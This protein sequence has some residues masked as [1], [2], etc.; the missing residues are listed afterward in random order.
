[1][2]LSR[3]AMRFLGVSGVVA[4]PVVPL[5]QALTRRYGRAAGKRFAVAAAAAMLMQQMLIAGALRRERRS[6]RPHEIGVA[7]LMT[8]TRGTASAVLA[9]LVAAGVRDRRGFAGW[10]AWLWLV[11]AAIVCDW[12]DGPI[13]RHLGA[14][15]IGRVFD[16]EEDSWLT[17][18][19][20]VAAVRWRDAPVYAVLPPVVRYPVLLLV[21]R[22]LTYAEIQADEPPWVRPVGMAQMLLY[23]ASLAPFGGPLT[24]AGVAIAAP[25]VAP[26]Q[27]AVMAL[28]Y[29][30]RLRA[31]KG[32]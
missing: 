1:M 6:G 8:L 16:L 2:L 30:R 26:A 9:G 3:Q 32:G 14:S 28:L 27:L 31:G 24:R 11:Y 10:M 21:M 23:L 18:V 13:A 20:A 4:A 22:R 7:D 5:S 12:L 19:S 25:V 29:G 15:E 17:L